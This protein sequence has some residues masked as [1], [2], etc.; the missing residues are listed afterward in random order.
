MNNK[1]EKG[2]GY[3]PPPENIEP[4]KNPPPPPPNM[5]GPAFA[6]PIGALNTVGKYSAAQRGMTL[7]DFFAAHAPLPPINT[8]IFDGKTT[9]ELLKKRVKAALLYAKTMI[10]EREKFLNGG[11]DEPETTAR[12]Q[13]S[14][15]V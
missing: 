5:G 10:A 14:D 7:F 2:L 3:N 12:K 15:T 9:E 1:R 6:R 4:P 11:D 13:G 8:L